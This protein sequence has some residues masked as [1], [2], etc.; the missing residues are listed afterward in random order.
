MG[1]RS[2]LILLREN[3]DDD[4]MMKMM[5][6]YID[7]WALISSKREE[8]QSGSEEVS[9]SRAAQIAIMTGENF[10]NVSQSCNK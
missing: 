1:S 8:T 4:V 3:D 7:A 5:S 6:S 9:E 10:I 2:F